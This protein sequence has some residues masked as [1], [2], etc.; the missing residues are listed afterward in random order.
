MN[1]EGLRQAG[2]LAALRRAAD[3]HEMEKA[4]CMSAFNTTKQAAVKM[5][6]SPAE[7]AQALI[8][9]E[10]TSGPKWLAGVTSKK[11]PV[12]PPG[13]EGRGRT[14]SLRDVLESKGV[15]VR[16]IIK[17]SQDLRAIGRF[18]ALQKEAAA[19]EAL[20]HGAKVLSKLPAGV[21]KAFAEMGEQVSKGVAVDPLKPGVAAKALGGAV[22][23]APTAGAI[24]GAG[25]VAKP[26]VEPYMRSK[27][28]QFHMRQA[29]TRPHFDPR[30]QRFM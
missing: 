15:D 23:H 1:Y 18:V 12:R 4:E 24:L 16:P 13:V 25:Y 27:M 20:G 8:R 6:L 26:H 10:G 2:A 9:G 3:R 5:K 29:A 11:W 22:R 17:K 30:T 21:R 7:I 14:P 28:M 19:V